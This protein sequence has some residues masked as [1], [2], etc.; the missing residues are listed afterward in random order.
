MVLDAISF[1]GDCILSNI[2]DD[3]DSVFNGIASAVNNFPPHT[4]SQ[5]ELT[6]G[7]YNIT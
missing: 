7:L 6:N 3:N 4:F 2:S 5:V 1:N